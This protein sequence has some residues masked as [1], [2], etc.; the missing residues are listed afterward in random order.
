[1][2]ATTVIFAGTFCLLGLFVQAYLHKK[3]RR[4][5]PIRLVTVEFGGLPS[6]PVTFGNKSLYFLTTNPVLNAIKHTY[7]AHAVKFEIYHRSFPPLLIGTIIVLGTL[8]CDIIRISE[9][10]LTVS[11]CIVDVLCAV[12]FAGILLLKGFFSGFVSAITVAYALYFLI[13]EGV[14]KPIPLFGELL[15]LVLEV[16]NG[17]A[18]LV[19]SVLWLCYGIVTSWPGTPNVE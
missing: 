18:Q 14:F 15:S 3:S 8:V 6:G 17:T 2:S 10:D 4:L 7:N 19:Y 13:E 5:I 16:Q 11:R 12:I 1:M 9:G